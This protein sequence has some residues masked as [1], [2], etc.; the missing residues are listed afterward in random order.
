[1]ADQRTILCGLPPGLC[2]QGS[3]K[4]KHAGTSS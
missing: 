2:L 3:V 4:I 1:M